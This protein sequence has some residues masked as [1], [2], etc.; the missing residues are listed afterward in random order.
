MK[1]GNVQRSTFGLMS[2]R[3][4]LTLKTFSALFI[5]PVRPVIDSMAAVSRGGSAA[6][7]HGGETAKASEASATADERN[8]ED[9]SE[10][11]R[12]ALRARFPSPVRLVIWAQRCKDGS[13]RT[14][15]GRVAWY[16]NSLKAV[17]LSALVHTPTLPAPVM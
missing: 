17:T 12:T 8:M 3:G 6:W 15:Q 5:V 7:T 2:V 16:A 14:A 1:G 11:C 13:R 9:P 10:S 4:L